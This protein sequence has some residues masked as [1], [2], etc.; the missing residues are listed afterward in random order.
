MGP[1]LIVAIK[2]FE[3]SSIPNNR[4]PNNPGVGLD[5]MAEGSEGMG[6]HGLPDDDPRRG[7]QEVVGAD[8][9]DAE[10]ASPGNPLHDA[11]FEWLLSYREEHLEA[12]FWL[13]RRNVR[14]KL[15]QGYW[16]QGTNAY[17]SVGLYNLK[18]NNLSTKAV[19]LVFWP[20]EGHYGVY[21]LEEPE[22]FKPFRDY[23]K[24]RFD[25]NKPWT[26]WAPIGMTLKLAWFFFL[27]LI[28]WGK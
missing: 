13:R 21:P 4:D 6:R 24:K 19:A 26:M 5:P 9:G 11:T 8:E 22:I 1:W 15:H 3:M 17:A 10:T 20:N 12:Y 7:S 18:S 28:G 27:R 25:Q 23:D 14:K 16:F 2:D